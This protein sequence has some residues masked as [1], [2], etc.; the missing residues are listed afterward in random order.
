MRSEQLEQP[1]EVVAAHRAHHL[2]AGHRDVGDPGHR[3]DLCRVDGMGERRADRRPGQVAQLGQGA[4]LD[5]A[6]LA[7]DADPVAQ[8]LHLGQDVA[9]QQDRAAGL[10]ELPDHLAEDRLHERVEARG[11]LVE[12]EQLDVGGQ[13]RDEGHLLPVALGVGAALLRRVEVEALDHVGS[14][15]LVDATAQAGE[16]VDDLPPVRLGHRATSPG[17]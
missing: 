17:T 15:P 5:V 2:V 14:A 7:D 10:P 8:V 16:D 11:R 13:G 4:G 9:R 6:P 12:Q 1:P 3:L